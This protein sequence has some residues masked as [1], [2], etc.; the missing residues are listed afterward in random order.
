MTYLVSLLEPVYAWIMIDSNGS[1]YTLL[2]IWFWGVCFNIPF[3]KDRLL[4]AWKLIELLAANIFITVEILLPEYCLEIIALILEDIRGLVA[5]FE[6]WW[7]THT[8]RSTCCDS[9]SVSLATGFVFCV[10]GTLLSNSVVKATRLTHWLS[11]SFWLATTF[12][13]LSHDS[14]AS[15]GFN[16]M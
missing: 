3:C 8:L 15:L 9:F 1:I 4:L 5:R 16:I 14:V 2:A 7:Y 10:P 12:A 6:K 11:S 13:A